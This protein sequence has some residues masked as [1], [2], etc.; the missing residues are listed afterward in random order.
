MIN[1]LILQNM[2]VF[3][4]LTGLFALSVQS[5]R[6]Q[7]EYKDN[8]GESLLLNCT[9]IG[10]ENGN[11]VGVSTVD[12]R[13]GYDDKWRTPWESLAINHD[14][15]RTLQWRHSKI[16]ELG[17]FAFKDLNYLDKVDLSHNRLK[18]IHGYSFNNFNLDL[19]D[20]DLSHNSFEQVP[21]ELFTS[22]HT[23]SIEVLRMNENQIVYLT[24][25]SL[26]PIR[27]SL[28]SIEFN[29]CKIS[30]IEPGAF[31]DMK[32][33]ESVSLIGNHLKYLAEYN[34]R[35]LT[36]RSFYIHENPFV[37]DCHLRWLISYLKNVDYHQ[38]SYESQLASSG[39]YL[40]FL[41]ALNIEWGFGFNL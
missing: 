16:I 37:C 28:K 10:I 35:D 26:S 27:Q 30:S 39:K 38:Q 6:I 22:K 14:I 4:I 24:R 20:I 23:Q 13:I 32:S 31:D 18:S 12:Q 3:V 29:Y 15:I 19:R 41:I 40:L 21:V 8:N 11:V 25:S 34:F 36:L 17:E 2:I 1:K 7:C 9:L 33:L 5:T